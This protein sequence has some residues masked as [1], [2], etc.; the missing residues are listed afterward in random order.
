MLDEDLRPLADAEH[1][2][3]PARVGGKPGIDFNRRV[4]KAEVSVPR[5]Y[6][7]AIDGH[8]RSEELAALPQAQ[9]GQQL[10]FRNRGVA[11]DAN[12]FNDGLRVLDDHDS[13][14]ERDITVR[15]A[16]EAK[17]LLGGALSAV[18]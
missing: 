1:D 2:V 3:G 6:R 9:P 14:A 16:G 12:R 10:D 17:R 8:L 5:L 15:A 11:L 7:V 18:R 4:Q 13:D